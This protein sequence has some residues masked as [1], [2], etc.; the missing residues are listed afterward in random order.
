M[1]DAV[2]HRPK[3]KGERSHAVCQ[4]V[5]R[6]AFIDDHIDDH[7]MVID[8]CRIELTGVAYHTGYTNG[9]LTKMK[10]LFGRLT[11]NIVH[12]PT[13]MYCV[14]SLVL[15]VLDNNGVPRFLIHKL[16]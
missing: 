10:E 16:L 3:D 1:T 9:Q 12:G 4:C 2:K 8:Q 7:C 13:V 11:K 5:L 6:F 15:S 14:H